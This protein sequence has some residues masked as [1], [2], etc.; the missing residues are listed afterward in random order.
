MDWIEALILGLVQGLT[1]FLP[2]SSSGHL[3]IG[4][5]LL[6][7]NAEDN[8]RFTVVVHGATVLSTL[9]VFRK[10]ILALIQGL[11]E[12]K[13]NDSTQYVTK[14]AF[15]MLPIAVVGLFFKDQVEEI[16]NTDK[17]LLLVG[18]MLLLTAS[19]LAFTFYAKQ[20]EKEISFRDA[21]IIGVAQTCAV[22]PGISRSGSTIAT[23]L[24][25]GNKKSEVA[26]FSFLMVLV[27]IIGENIL[28]IFK[29]DI[30]QAGSIDTSVLIVGF[31]AAFVSG[32]LACSW[33]IKIVKKGKLIYFAIYCLIIGLI[34]IFAS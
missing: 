18:F 1:E 15:S 10:D 11:F 2:V 7:V 27:P 4:K 32:L 13:W 28:S 23:G 33:M 31:I 19:L 3:E 9:I 6:G 30:S 12:F 34:A 24:L 29:T 25:L 20:K 21:L 22:L 17:I 14:I 8:L 5:A 16:F 26:K